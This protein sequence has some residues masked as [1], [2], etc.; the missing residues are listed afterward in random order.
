LAYRNGAR[1]IGDLGTELSELMSRGTALR[2]VPGIGED[3]AKKIQEILATGSCEFLE[4]LHQE[5]PAGLLD[6]L[7]LPG[8]GPRRVKLL[9]DEL[10][11]ENLE[12]LIAAA[13]AGQIRGLAR[14][15]EKT[16][17]NLLE[18][19]RKRVA[20]TRRYPLTLAASYAQPLAAHLRTVTG[21]RHVEI[22]GSFRR[23]RP[24]VGDLDI[25]VVAD[26]AAPVMDHFVGY[27]EVIDVL[28]KG[29][30]RASVLLRPGLQVDLRCVPQESFGAAM[31]YFTG[32]KAH[33]VAIRR[34][35]QARGLKM[36]E[37]GVFEGERTVAGTTEDSVYASIGL[38]WITP[39]LR[40]NR[41]EVAAAAA[42]TLPALVELADLRAD[43][44]VRSKGIGGADALETL[45]AQ[46]EAR[47]FHSLALVLNADVSTAAEAR[48]RAE[49][50]A[51]INRM[52]RSSTGFML[53]KG[54]E[55]DI[56]EDGSLAASEQTLQACDVVIASVASALD[57]PK[58]AQTE[59]LL[60][61]LHHP[62]TAILALARQTDTPHAGAMDFDVAAVMRLA[63]ERN[64]AIEMTLHGRRVPM[65]ENYAWIAK[66]E[67]VLVSLSSDASRLVDFETLPFITGIARRAWM[68]P[69]DVLNAMSLDQLKHWLA[70][71]HR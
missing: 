21:V 59:R 39:E 55:V 41:G 54:V 23:M 57:L 49:H 5:V 65:P 44:H 2:D 61:A 18:A 64:V 52:N 53:W 13:Q 48:E 6:L 70:T 30:T 26:E 71:H 58:A 7:K 51:E 27:I 60:R 67:G 46:A 29:P 56:Q 68:G 25:V 20:M 4:R 63:K 16:E 42:A 37:Y 47:G 19:A 38:P 50:S 9:Y 43:L 15:G 40:E 33:N 1:S 12:H 45:V 3:L 17:Q 32:S 24:H 36:N 22:A 35:A 11:I 28:S 34:M 8:L 10:H 69:N 31:V 62:R 14:F 66:Q